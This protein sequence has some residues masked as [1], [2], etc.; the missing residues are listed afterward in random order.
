MWWLMLLSL[1]GVK[2]SSG[3]IICP[4]NQ[5]FVNC[6]EPSSCD[7]YDKFGF[8]NAYCLSSCTC[9]Y[10]YVRTWELPE[11]FNLA[12]NELNP[13]IPTAECK[14][15]DLDVKQWLD[16]LKMSSDYDFY[17]LESQEI[18]DM[19]RSKLGDQNNEV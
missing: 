4:K 3:Y 7:S 14:S 9:S 11:N 12:N 1:F 8:E 15:R 10:G 16:Q 2:L 17:M 18:Y 6:I 19:I 5:I 13:C